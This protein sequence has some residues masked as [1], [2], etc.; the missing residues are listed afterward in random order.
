MK[1]LLKII[2]SG[3]LVIAA[4]IV[5]AY[6]RFQMRVNADAR[7][8]YTKNRGETGVIVTADMLKGL[9]ESVQRYLTYSGIVGKPLV[10]TVRL[11]QAGKF[12]QS[13][14]QPWMDAT[15]HEYYSINPPGLVWDAT[16]HAAGLP[17][18]RGFD[19]Y[20]SAQGNMQGNVAAIY[21]IFN[22]KGA[23]LTQATMVRYLNEM[24]WFPSAFLSDY[25]TWTGRDDHSADVTFTDGGKSVTATMYFDEEG[26][27]TNFVA[28]RYRGWGN[29]FILNTWSTPIDAYGELAGLRL[30]VRGR[31]VWNLPEGDL[32][33]FDL[34]ITDIEYNRP[35]TY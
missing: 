31:A 7:D 13:A 1:R 16:F 23:E 15:A 33:Y 3:I 29:D 20:R 25:I 35:E 14:E 6:I 30:P 9:P 2:L 8:L 26:K 22:V 4:V 19:R 5:G 12:R 34:Q 18:M 28:Q 24:M 11:K 32:A 21:P 10:N 17:L 27:L